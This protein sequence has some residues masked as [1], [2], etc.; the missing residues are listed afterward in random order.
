VTVRDDG[1]AGAS[2]RAA[3]TSVTVAFAA[4]ALEDIARVAGDAFALERCLWVAVDLLREGAVTRVA[5][6]LRMAG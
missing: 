2:V 3:G 6:D 4:G 1:G 5:V